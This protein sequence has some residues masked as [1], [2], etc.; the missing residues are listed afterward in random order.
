MQLFIFQPIP[1][2]QAFF[3]LLY[4]IVIDVI[5]LIRFAYRRQGKCKATSKTPRNGA[6]NY[7]KGKCSVYW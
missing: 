1:L 7:N 2:T 4:K 3:L 6:K 5:H